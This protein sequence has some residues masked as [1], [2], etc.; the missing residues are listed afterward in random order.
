MVLPWETYMISR[1]CVYVSRRQIARGALQ[2]FAP[3]GELVIIIADFITYSTTIHICIAAWMKILFV[4]YLNM[5]GEATRSWRYW[6]ECRKH[7]LELENKRLCIEL[8]LREA[9]TL[10]PATK[11]CSFVIRPGVCILSKRWWESCNTYYMVYRSWLI[12]IEANHIDGGERSRRWDKVERQ[13]VFVQWQPVL[14]MDRETTGTEIV[15]DVG[16]VSIW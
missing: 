8:T 11:Q 16:M 5:W 1:Y 2:N 10:P 7:E 3:N 15:S 14:E 6:N 12:G 13:G 4:L 9:E